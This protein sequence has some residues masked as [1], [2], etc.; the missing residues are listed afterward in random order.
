MRCA[1]LALASLAAFAGSA[2]GQATFRGLG[3]I[4]GGV[5]YSEGHSLSADRE[6]AVGSSLMTGGLSGQTGAYSWTS[7]LGMVPLFPFPGPSSVAVAASSDGSVIAGWADYGLFSPLG[8]QGFFWTA[9]TGPVLIG[10]LP[11]NPGTGLRSLVRAI[12]ADGQVLAGDGN[13][14][15]GIDAFIYR[16]DTSQFSPLGSLSPTASSSWAY[17]IS[18]DGTVVVGASY[19]A[20]N[21][22]RAYRWTQSTGMVGLAYL[23][24]SV[25]VTPWSQAEAISASGAVIVGQ[26]RSIAS[27]NALEACRWAQ[28]GV[29]GLG[30]L[31]GGAF[32]SWA[33]AVSADGSIIVGRATIEGTPG[34]FGGG[35]APRAFIWD[36]ANG[37]R[38]LQAVLIAGGAAIQGWSL[39]EAR[40]ISADG[41]TFTGTGV[42]AQ[43]Q[44]EAWYAT[45]PVPNPPTCYANCDNSTGSPALT[46]NDFQCFLNRFVANDPYANCDASTGS[47]ALTA[48]D[49]QCFANQFA[50]G[51]S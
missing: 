37:I 5:T 30:D 29:Q 10:D 20:A 26:S 13:G 9:G 45:I 27:G 40:G 12:S 1:P 48:N 8:C 39:H 15:Q 49:F 47:P 44:F 34:P 36:A 14:A 16:R 33:Y 38:D 50:A 6:T 32:Q 2:S 31:P 24:T 35:S 3:Y 43:G 51:C 28:K 21:Q 41:S 42:N 22:L 4:A 25:G 7:E 18:A 19:A 11:T 17:D 23:P 46:A